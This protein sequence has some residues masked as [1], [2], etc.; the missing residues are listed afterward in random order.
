MIARSS[1]FKWLGLIFTKV[2]NKKLRASAILEMAKV[3]F[4]SFN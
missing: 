1:N 4:W 2:E 3:V